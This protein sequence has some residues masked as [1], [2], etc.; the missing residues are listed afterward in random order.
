M[1]AMQFVLSEQAEESRPGTRTACA[2]NA[3]TAI[4]A[5]SSDRDLPFGGGRLQQPL[6]RFR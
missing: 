3:L 1:V 2:R 6:L 5:C 4:N